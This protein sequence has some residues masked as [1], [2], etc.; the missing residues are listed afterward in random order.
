MNENESIASYIIRELKTNQK[1]M[2][3][4]LV[5]Y[6]VVSSAILVWSI[7]DSVQMRDKMNTLLKDMEIIEKCDVDVKD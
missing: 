1:R 2:F 7:I 6:F 3:V 5:L 4:F